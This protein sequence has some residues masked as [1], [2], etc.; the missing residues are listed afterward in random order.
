M[1][2]FVSWR[3]SD[4]DI[5]NELVAQLRAQLPDEQI[6]ESDEGCNSNAYEDFIEQIH[7]SEIFV[8]IVSDEAMK[9]SYVFNEI[10]EAR[11]CEMAGNLNMLV[12]K[13]TD[14]PYTGTF[15]ANLNHLSDANHVARL[16]GTDE[17][18]ITLAN[19][20]KSLLEKRR[21]GEPEN[22]YDTFNP[23]IKGTELGN[24]YYVP[25]SRDDIFEKFDN[26]FQSSNIIIASQISGYGKRC[27]VREYALQNRDIKKKVVLHSFSGSMRQ[28]F[29]NGLEID[30]INSEV[31]KNMSENDVIIAKAR[32]LSRLDKST[33]VIVPDYVPDKRDDRFVFDALSTFGCRVIFIAQSVPAQ[34]KNVFPV[35]SVDRMKD[36]Y[37]S[38]L[39]FNYYEASPEE[40]YELEEP[41]K[42]FFDSIDGHTKSVEI[43][44]NFLADE[45]GVYPEEIP[46]IL[47]NI[48]PDSDN[49]L[50]E[51]IF[52]LIS[53][54]F[55][56]KN[57][58]QTERAILLTATY[59]AN[60]PIDEKFFVEL[61]QS[62]DCHDGKILRSLIERGWLNNDRISRT[63]W[64][65]GF[66]AEVCRAKIE[67]DEMLFAKLLNVLNDRF[68]TEA[69]TLSLG[70]MY[71]TLRRFGYFFEMIGLIDLRNACEQIN[72]ATDGEDAFFTSQYETEEIKRAALKYIAEQ[73]ENEDFKSALEDIAD[74]VIMLLTADIS[75]HTPN[76]QRANKSITSR[77]ISQTM[78]G[79]RSFTDLLLDEL[80]NIAD[81]KLKAC[82]EG[83]ILAANTANIAQ[84]VTAYELL[85]KILAFSGSADEL[86]LLDPVY[87]LGEHIINCIRSFDYLTLRAC[88]AWKR[89]N[90]VFGVYSYART[91][92]T[93]YIYLSTLIKLNIFD[94]ELDEVFENTLAMLNGAKKEGYF[95]QDGLLNSDTSAADFEIALYEN[96]LYGLTLRGDTEKGEEILQKI[97]NFTPVTKKSLN[98]AI[99]C[100]KNIIRELIRCGDTDD[101]LK[102]ADKIMGGLP[103]SAKNDPKSIGEGAADALDEITLFCEAIEENNAPCDF[104]DYS[105]EYMDYYRKFATEYTN[106][107][108]Y[109]KYEEIATKAKALDYSEHSKEMLIAI[110]DKL[111]KRALAG[112]A[113][114]SLAIEAFALISEAGYRVLGYRH[115]FVQLIGA[116]AIADG[117]I[118]EIQNGE[119]KTYTII[120]SA[121]LH[122]LYGRHVYIIDSSKYLS[123]R[124]Y[125]WMKDVLQ[126]LGCNVQQLDRRSPLKKQDYENCNIIYAYHE[127]FIFENM[128]D[129]LHPNTVLPPADVV[130]VDEAEVLLV[131]NGNLDY[132]LST[133]KSI[134]DNTS[135]A[136]AVY[137]VVAAVDEDI[138]DKY[139]SADS[140]STTIKAPLFDLLYD[141]CEKMGLDITAQSTFAEGLL[142][143]CIDALFVYQKD[144]DYFIINGEIRREDKKSGGFVR[145]S[146]TFTYFL[147]KKENLS[148]DPNLL[149]QQKP[150]NIYTFREF[151]NDFHMLCG[152]TA[153]ASGMKKEFEE[154]YGL[155]VVP[156]PT[157]IPIKRVDYPPVIFTASEAKL[158]HIIELVNEK[159]KSG[160]PLL[161]VTES[162]F[163]STQ[164]SKEFTAHNITHRL[165]NAKNADTQADLLEEAGHL[166]AITVTTSIANRGVDI[167]L[168]G[169]AK[170]MAKKHLLAAGFSEQ[171]IESDEK[172][173]KKLQDIT[174]YYRKKT[175]ADKERI[176]SLGG[177]CVIGTSC[178]SN[179]ST[180]Q[181]MRGR[182]GRQG[183]KG[184]SHVFFSIDDYGFKQLLGQKYP[185]FIALINSM[186]LQYENLGSVGYL[187]KSI[188]KA[189][190][191]RQHQIHKALLNATEMLYRP[192]AR[193]AILGL[194]KNLYKNKCNIR[195][196]LNKYFFNAP[197]NIADV[198][199]IIMGG[200][201]SNVPI[202][203]LMKYIDINNISSMK[204]PAVLDAAVKAFREKTDN[205]VTDDILA[206]IIA[207]Y[208]GYAWSDFLSDMD[209][210]VNESKNFYDSDRK[211]QKHIKLYYKELCEELITLSVSR[212]MIAQV[213]KTPPE[214]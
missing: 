75:M 86:E 156:I 47:Q 137:K 82:L 89:L 13:L 35:V 134:H 127:D 80:D 139:F 30:N 199:T 93:Y 44:A 116:A 81:P 210:E 173:A 76:E 43:T 196:L 3:G 117:K 2:I 165:L 38:E 96:Y 7:R 59:F 21:R 208:L 107:K 166:G 140:S 32:L 87:L 51:R 118:A 69:A 167:K 16:K 48:H 136:E 56:M 19:R 138:K 143:M 212:A 174:A 120:A 70:A 190:T 60:T 148:P 149:K 125:L 111:K 4:R 24:G 112:E 68:I 186:N 184:E 121:F 113:K 152:A 52:E 78:A 180:E 119:G 102:L 162:V 50:S 84:F 57:F 98:A 104:E 168:G 6:W 20:I 151:F 178:F 29:I 201:S 49:E 192:D 58:G 169:N 36:E 172:T 145:F 28:F 200:K 27:A 141:E 73:F 103:S 95:K 64:I 91:F 160:Q 40:Q 66:F 31:F 214:K 175:E 101:A 12:F 188:E 158:Q 124:N 110:A 62:A 92:S 183:D 157:N 74:S 164:L 114:E 25:N 182:C 53:E 9:P 71:T 198:T 170:A 14:S 129:E 195:N 130:I 209:Y 37:L 207:Q 106:K 202:N 46:E 122:Y 41:L 15:A 54:L 128:A 153:T 72:A 176:N 204:P 144:R 88:R 11:A 1:S 105:Y 63:V 194:A 146:N 26:A 18:Y 185:T 90:D 189:R 205:R 126:Y 45:F 155:E 100:G 123:N 83:F 161:I 108:L 79:I 206:Q 55:D 115:H 77:L 109:R 67:K 99:V 85:V 150:A 97:F 181:Q 23:E 94:Q 211:F 213:R 142:K 135:V 163:E 131:E 10:I 187:T 133:A 171:D 193:A 34:I 203:A 8:V 65:D 197:A 179:L 22:P 42:E 132:I 17:G 191:D 177:L 154:I 61:L 159:R 39:F 5:K 147:C 33:L